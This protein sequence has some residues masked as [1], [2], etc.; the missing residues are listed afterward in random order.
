MPIHPADKGGQNFQEV[1]YTIWW[2]HAIE[3][4]QTDVTLSFIFYNFQN[5]AYRL[6]KDPD[7]GTHNDDK[8]QEWNVKFD[9]NDAWMWKWLFPK[10]ED[11]ILNPS[12]FFAQDIGAQ[13]GEWMETGLKHVFTIPGIDN[14]T[15]TPS[16]KVAA[17]NS[18]WR[19]GFFLA[20]EELALNTAYDLTPILHL[21]KWAGTI[22]IGGEIHYWRPWG[23][24]RKPPSPNYHVET[25][26]RDQFWGGMT[27]TWA[28][29][30]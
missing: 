11:G 2:K 6:R 15:I 7:P 27:V 21:P 8:S 20:G 12:F 30:G 22:S 19:H 26:Q 23:Q 9:H 25:E 4:I 18:F 24:M 13:P 10:N 29:G 16:Y 17:Q 14:L 3:P 1:D 28:W 5:A